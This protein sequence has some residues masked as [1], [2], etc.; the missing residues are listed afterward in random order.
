[1]QQWDRL[2]DATNRK[3]S[4][5]KEASEGQAFHRNLEDIDL[6]L[7]EC[8]AQLANDDL[9]KD[10]TSVQ[11]LHK[12]LGDLESDI[13]ARKER[14]EAIQQ[15]AQQFEQAGHFDAPN[16]VRK[17]SA[18]VTKFNSLFEPIQQRKAKLAESSQLQ[19][20][21]RDIE[22]EET[23]IREKEPAVGLSSASNRGRDLIG[24]K[25]LCQKHQALMAELAGHEPR[26]RQTCNQAADMIER[27][28]FAAD[29]V[30]KRIVALQAKWQLLKDKA[31]QRKQD[32]D[33]S[34]KVQQYLTDA[35][36]AES[37]MREK[38]PI[39]DS[40]DYGKDE[41]AA[42]ALLK[43]H[44]ALMADIEA[45]ESTIYGDLKAEAQECKSERQ[46]QQQHQ[47]DASGINRQCVVALYDYTE[48]TPREVSVRKGDVV[49]LLNSNNQ[50]WW[51]VE[52]NDRQG[53]VPAAYVKKIEMTAAGSGQDHAGQSLLEGT[54]V[55]S[56][57]AR[58]QQ[59][60]NEYQ[61]LLALGRQR[62]NKLQEACDAHKLVREAAELTN[63]IA[64]KEKIASEQNLGETPDE[65][66]V[67]TRRFDDFKKDLKVNEARIVELNK[68][69]ERLR[70]MNQQEAAKKIQDEIEVLNIRWTELQK[71]TATRQHR[72]LSAHE[73]QRFQRDADETM[74]WITEKNS[75]LNMDVEY[76]HDL[77]SV[78]RLQRKHDGFERDLDAL[79]DRIRELDD[80]SQ[81][82]MNTH[83]DQAEGIYEKQIK[84]QQAWTEL[85][86]KADARKAKLIESYDYQSFMAHFRDLTSWINS[87]IT[88]VSSEE[89]AKD[90][91]GAEA[92]LE[93]HHEHRMEIDA[94]GETFQEFEDFGSHLISTN[95]Y[96]S[97]NIRDRLVE[98]QDAR[99]N[100]ERAWKARQEK[101]D[102]CLEL[103]L[104][105]RD[106]ETAEHWMKS[107]ENA[108]K[109]D[110]N[111]GGA[112]SV[113]A[114]IKRHEDF[115]RAINAQEEKIANLQTFASTLIG[116]NHY[117]SE[118]V[119]GRIERVLERWQKLRQALLEHRSKLGESQ[120]LQDFSRDAD[121][122][123]A[124]I[125]EKLAATSDE[126]VK[127]ATNIQSKQQKH[128]VL[129]AELTANSDRIQSVIS[130]GK[131]LIGNDKCPGLEGE[132]DN[133][134]SRITEQWEFLVSKSTEK[135]LRLKEASKQQ[136]FNAGV[137]DIEF[138]LGLVENQLQNEDY[139]RDLATVQNL[140]KKHQLIEAD[141]N[142]HEEPIKDLN[143]TAEQFISNNLFD[144]NAIR[145]TI[146]SINDRYDNV[147][148]LTAGR[149]QRLSE[150]NTLF[151]FFRDL[152]DEEAWIRE[153]KL[154]VG[155]E[156][157]GR[158]LTGVQNLR[159]KHKRLEAE[160][161]SHEPAIQQVQ[162]LANKLLSESNI[163]ANDIE[164]KR[165][166]LI[167]NWQDLKD[168]TRERGQKL[169]QS[170]AYQNWCAA[171][172]E[173]RAWIN[174]KQHVIR[175]GELG[176]TLASAQGLIK[177]HDAFETDFN[178]HKERLEDII[179]Q[180][181][182]L[183]QAD[184][185]HKVNIQDTLTA[186]KEMIQRL[187][188]DAQARKDRLQENWAMLQFF[189]KADVVESWIAEKQAQLQTDDVGHNLSSVQ[190]LLAKHDT[191]TSGLKAFENEG[192]RTI[193]QLKDQLAGSGIQSDKI[194]Q[195]FNQVI[196]RWQTL[197]A[198]SD[199]RKSV[200]KVAEAK[201][202]DIEE[203]FLLFA[204]KASTFN[205]WFEN[206]EE[207]LTD[208]VRCN[209]IDEIHELIKAH[210]RFMSTLS[211]ALVEFEELQQLDQRIKQLQMGP[212][213]Y[214]WFTMDT[215]RDTWRS[216]Q[217]AI[218][219][220]EA[221]LE[222]E[223]RRQD[224]NDVLRQRFAELASRFYAWLSDTRNEMMEIGS[225]SSSLEQQLA[226]TKLKSDE[227]RSVKQEF[228]KI[229]ELSSLLEAK[230]ILDNKYTEHSTLSLAQ[231]WDQ[232][233]QLGMRMQHN[234]EQQ[235]QARNQSGVTE[236]SLREFS[237][238]FKHFDRE[239]S[240]RLNHDEFKSCLRALGYDLPMV[241]EG[242]PDLA[243]ESI[244][245]VV[246]PNR[247]GFVNLQDYMA[248]MIS[249]ETDNI[250]SVGDVINAFKALTE[251]GERPY[252]TKEELMMNL[253]TNQVEYCI[254]KMNPYK[255]KSGREVHNAYD[256][257]EFTH[258]LFT[259]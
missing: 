17:Q 55:A 161:T 176:N 87:M 138:W 136:T 195:K 31:Q 212:N 57:A 126:T 86:Q 257:E 185:H 243:F 196:K 102:Q 259:S 5:L 145:S 194:G 29:E 180:G 19:Q 117:D 71:V 152:D 240:G 139:G 137:K 58:Q 80:V 143:T 184:N 40:K 91:P 172:E 85:T 149:R 89:L 239:K 235:I 160:L 106:C 170:L 248:F 111:K 201:Y 28:H 186:A 14:I 60:E 84:I 100:L 65:V 153:K 223:K 36:E 115:D 179:K 166:Q 33:D 12:K 72:L 221:D 110:G 193:I 156:D 94:R 228:K 158:D 133:R 258:S 131:N 171:I 232:L 251:N 114:A 107:R 22:D 51:K 225:T 64:D 173:E 27:K 140:F 200:L 47:Q 21:L 222:A 241:E 88:Q 215:L 23:W 77:P 48:K 4:R 25:N 2:V 210:E 46:Q 165:N 148:N 175:S 204:K 69:A 42:E 244:L 34:L 125:M 79:G 18:L 90:V 9:G 255:D 169:D 202:K 224:E 38:E 167:A 177:K 7:S 54:N 61:R 246:D 188:E 245:D 122:I 155:S 81:R 32:L 238:M 3:S 226:A 216:L 16:I 10:L 191:F 219:D 82:L 75:T 68:I 50:D 207:D 53:F 206:A 67:L 123:E 127:D 254:S 183:I 108:L 13:L 104:F 99:N 144:T 231:A 182:A 66:E 52:V 190:N 1:M 98:M 203:L 26:I 93:R 134:L 199:S 214:T 220:R 178:V 187:S 105:N 208:P 189:W 237:M 230:L 150:A 130:M 112:E 44:Q 92:L 141:V 227:I 151:Q 242:A 97:Q 124:W 181:Q 256:Y 154:M 49:T 213:P 8:E 70:Q 63:W 78:K 76:G 118:N 253:P 39:V 229:E 56:V 101:L 95:H 119:K 135:S 164:R 197:L 43:K 205:S 59:I 247:D 62:R 113:E 209:S 250:S 24:V 41:D 74:D 35:A 73:V 11:N 211:S 157:Y 217:K 83:P 163:G 159:K 142:A 233:D 174:E 109:D 37:W 6:W 30:K 128:Q 236:E 146:D 249:K 20:L 132:V 45:Y 15:T 234:L 218:K 120:T 252:I 147:K 96:E 103:Q 116:S 162:E 129:G 121:E 168:L 192:I 198:A